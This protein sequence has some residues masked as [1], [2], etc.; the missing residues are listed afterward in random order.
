MGQ[1]LRDPGGEIA[2]EAV[3]TAPGCRAG[4]RG[5]APQV[6]VIRRS[7]SSQLGRRKRPVGKGEDAQD[8][9]TLGRPPGRPGH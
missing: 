2:V 9:A 4:A 8:A 6:R 3:T 5:R 7:D 1:R